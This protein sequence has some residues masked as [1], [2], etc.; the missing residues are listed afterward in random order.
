MNTKSSGSFQS[1]VPSNFPNR[2]S[3]NTKRDVDLFDGVGG[4][5]LAAD[6]RCS[7]SEMC[8]ISSQNAV[9]G[10]CCL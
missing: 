4:G 2:K 9:G 1:V 8:S 6:P 10:A 5:H 3:A 7:L